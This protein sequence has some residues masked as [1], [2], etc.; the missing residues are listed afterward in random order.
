[1]NKILLTTF[2][3][4]PTQMTGG[5]NKIICE[6][7]KK[8]DYQNNSVTYFSKNYHKTFSDFNKSDYPVDSVQVSKS[9]LGRYFYR[10]SKAYR[11]VVTTPF[12]LN[13]H[14]RAARK[15][16]E[17]F[18][19]SHINFNIIHTHDVL[20]LYYFKDHPAKKILTIHS[21][22]P[23]IDDLKDYQS[24][25]DKMKNWYSRFNLM[26]NEAIKAADVIAFP[27]VEAKK[28]F[29]NKKKEIDETKIKIIY[30]GIDI[31]KIKQLSNSDYRPNE[32]GI[33]E[34]HDLLL[35][36][37][38][39]HIKVKNISSIIKSVHYLKREYDRNPLLVNVGIGPETNHLQKMIN[40]MALRDNV[41][42]LGLLSN[43]EIIKFMN[44]FDYFIMASERV[45]FDLVILEA[46]ACGMIVMANNNG[47]N[48][49]IIKNGFNGY[50][51]NEIGAEEIAKMIMEANEGCR[52]QAKNSIEQFDSSKMVKEYEMLYHQTI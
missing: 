35:L 46:M 12:Y 28:L 29:L 14:Y 31:E 15:S 4:F 26:E 48:K 27:S 20:S 6:I 23:I 1:M 17:D 41:I 3:G 25:S 39:D 34:N 9:G 13:Y 36:N 40:E 45:V 16:F 43:D 5:P 11:K 47:G 19:N 38:A 21:K 24:R 52:V 32:Y 37:V 30:N 10:N 51:L 8:L 18:V 50:L 7:L 42:L 2:T 33:K 49:E 22:G 44:Y